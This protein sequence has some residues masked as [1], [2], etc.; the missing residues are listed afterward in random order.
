[1]GEA[2][3]LTGTCNSKAVFRDRTSAACAETHSLGA[4]LEQLFVDAPAELCQSGRLVRWPLAPCLAYHFPMIADE[5]RN[6]CFDRALR[7]AVTDFGSR[8]GRAP[9]MLDIGSGSGLLAMMAA[10]AGNAAGGRAIDQSSVDCPPQRLYP[11]SALSS[12]S[13]SSSAVCRA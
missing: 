9:H 8:E 11:T 6:G 12:D 7:A 3:T 1:M 5:G 10:R 4:P 13:D 2:V